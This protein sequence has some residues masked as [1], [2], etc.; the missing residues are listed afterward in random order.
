MNEQLFSSSYPGQ[1]SNMKP[2]A[3]ITVK[4]DP[5]LA[6]NFDF[7]YLFCK[8]VCRDALNVY[9]GCANKT[10]RSIL[11]YTCYTQRDWRWL[12]LPHL[13]AFDT[14][15]ASC[16]CICVLYT[17]MQSSSFYIRTTTPNKTVLILGN[18]LF[19]F[20]LY[21]NA[22]ESRITAIVIQIV[23]SIWKFQQR[24][25]DGSTHNYSPTHTL[26]GRRLDHKRLLYSSICD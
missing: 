15:Q 12:H 26:L 22:I 10:T 13:C 8:C 14:A 3:H 4:F 19:I 2:F 21:Q 1:T 5:Q 20:N 7:M 16:N 18:C 24:C 11:T 23:N 25:T 17:A 9:W 6:N